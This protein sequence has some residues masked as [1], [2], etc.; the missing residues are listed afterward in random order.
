MAGYFSIERN[1]LQH[2]L[3]LAEP[4]TRGQAWV[5][6]IGLANHKNGFIRVAGV[7]IDILRGQ[8]GWSELNLSKRW[9]W[10]R[11][12]VQ[13]FLVELKAMEMVTIK[14]ST[15]NTIITICNYEIYQSHDNESSTTEKPGNPQKSSMYHSV[16]GMGKNTE[17]KQ[18]NRN[19]ELFDLNTMYY[20]DKEIISSTTDRTTDGHQTDIRQDTNNNGKNEKK[21]NKRKKETYTYDFED[22]WKAFPRKDGSKIKAFE[23]FQ[24]AIKGG[25]NYEIIKRGIESYANH[26]QQQQVER[27]FIAHAA[28]WLA[29]RR[30]ESEYENP[31]VEIP[32]PDIDKLREYQRKGITLTPAQNAIL[33]ANSER[34]NV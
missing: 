19:N 34:K 20:E 33:N 27:R 8:C 1:L 22:F 3:W 2:T 28:T 18:D 11:G 23:F 25:I 26:M 12:K 32:I 5:D 7:R 31:I 24:K 9:K 30:W 6:L 13:R 15:R 10:S 29:Q 14:T 21:N 4:F 17:P 16:S